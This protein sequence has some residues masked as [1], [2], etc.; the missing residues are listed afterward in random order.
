MISVERLQDSSSAGNHSVVSKKRSRSSL[1]SPLNL[2]KSLDMVHDLYSG[3]GA[4]MDQQFSKD[5]MDKLHAELREQH[6]YACDQAENASR[7]QE[8]IKQQRLGLER[9]RKQICRQ[10]TQLSK[11]DE[12]RRAVGVDNFAVALH[13]SKDNEI[14]STTSIA[15]DNRRQAARMGR[16]VGIIESEGS[17]EASPCAAEQELSRSDDIE[18]SEAVKPRKGFECRYSNAASSTVWVK[19]QGPVQKRLCGGGTRIA[20]EL[21]ARRLLTFFTSSISMQTLSKTMPQELEF[22]ALEVR[23]AFEPRKGYGSRRSKDTI[24]KPINLTGRMCRKTL[25]EG[26][27]AAYLSLDLELR[28]QKWVEKCSVLSI[29][30]DGSGFN[31]NHQNG[32][33]LNYTFIEQIGT[34]ALGSIRLKATGRSHCLNSLPTADNI[35]KD[36][37]RVDGSL[38]DKE[39]PKNIVTQMAMSGVLHAIMHHPCCIFGFDKG[40]ETRGCGKGVQG[41]VRRNAFCGRGSPLEQIFV[42]REAID[43]AMQGENGVFLQRCMEFLGV[44][45]NQQFRTGLNTRKKPQQLEIDPTQPVPSLPHDITILHRRWDSDKKEH[46]V[47]NKITE[48]CGSRPSTKLNPMARYP[49]IRGGCAIGKYCEK[50]SLN[51]AGAAYTGCKKMKRSMKISMKVASEMRKIQNHV[52]LRTTIARILGT[53]GARSPKSEHLA[54][55]QALGDKIVGEYQ[56]KYP[57]GMPRPEKGVGSRWNSVQDAVTKQEESWRIVNA[58]FPIA[59]AHGDL[60]AR[61]RVSE[62]ICSATGFGK[63]D[64]TIHFSPNLGN[65]FFQL[66]SPSYI[67]HLAVGQLI[68]RLS[69]QVLLAACADRGE[70]AALVMGGVGSIVSKVDWVLR[71]LLFVVPSHA[72][73]QMLKKLN[74]RWSDHGYRKGKWLTTFRLCHRGLPSIE[75]KG[76][77]LLSTRL[78]RIPEGSL[79]K[80]PPALVDLYGKFYTPGMADAISRARDTMMAVCRMGGDGTVIPREYLSGK[81]CSTDR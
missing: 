4:T 2:Q 36:V 69:F 48:H 22:A 34:D 73:P 31:E 49:G 28:E 46:V 33:V 25:S 29:G 50:H 3:S 37:R 75:S 11:V 66:N 9:Y 15:E 58:A 74:P 10:S 21:I 52:L 32:V 72:G 38:F 47:L 64:L 26:L 53:K 80:E 76:R 67:L 35:S 39:V 45:A 18:E 81:N 57:R 71:R 14:L 8:I 7:Q 12:F 5:D 63:D 70:H 23:A 59:L 19:M 54:I 62:R 61:K 44:P 40:S 20:E 17:G 79:S 60:S 56:L 42:T 68:Y 78:E 43:A 27:H 55:R 30:V 51:R 65:C 16:A 77:A 6:Q 41:A 1:A 24:G 13:G